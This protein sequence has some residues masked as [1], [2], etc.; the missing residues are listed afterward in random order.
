MIQQSVQPVQAVARPL[1][2]KLG[3]F[4]ATGLEV[5]LGAGGLSRKAETGRGGLCDEV[6]GLDTERTLKAAESQAVLSV[7]RCI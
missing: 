7:F 5:E 4:E 3:N 6:Q 1:A 2:H